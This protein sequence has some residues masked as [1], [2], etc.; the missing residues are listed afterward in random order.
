MTLGFCPYK[1]PATHSGTS[2]GLRIVSVGAATQ[3]LPLIHPFD[4]PSRDFSDSP[5]AVAPEQHHRREPEVSRKAFARYD[6]NDGVCTLLR[7][8]NLVV[9]GLCSDTI[10][11]FRGTVELVG[12]L[13]VE[14]IMRCAR[15]GLVI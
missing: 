11:A 2:L 4:R 5:I 9:V 1:R 14:D 12:L 10:L 8:S 6:V 7:V 13:T 15:H 3:V